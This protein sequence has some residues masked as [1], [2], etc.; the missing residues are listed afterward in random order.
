MGTESDAAKGRAPA[1]DGGGD[2]ADWTMAVCSFGR[3]MMLLLL[4]TPGEVIPQKDRFQELKDWN[5]L[6][7]S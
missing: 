2:A 3:D 6:I 4:L 7:S 5:C 1:G